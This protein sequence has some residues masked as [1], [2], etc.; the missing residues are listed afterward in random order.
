MDER[1]RKSKPNAFT[2]ASFL[3]KIFIL[4]ISPLLTLG[5]KR[6]LEE[7]DLD[8]PCPSDESKLLTE[9]LEKY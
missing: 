5:K 1:S 7:K 9:L 8:D 2:N 6:P 3:S 4:Y